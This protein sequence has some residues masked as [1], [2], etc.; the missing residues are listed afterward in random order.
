MRNQTTSTI[1][2]TSTK[3]RMRYSVMGDSYPLPC[4]E[5]VRNCDTTEP[6]PNR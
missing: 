2:A 4:V 6:R 5:R 1:N 3:P